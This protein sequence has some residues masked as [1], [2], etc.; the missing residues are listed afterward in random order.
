[1]K[2]YKVGFGFDVHSFTNKR[3][4]LVLGGL[5]IPFPLGLAA[6][7]DGDV[8]LHSIADAICGAAGLGDIGD[9]FP[10]SS[11]KSK[12]I[13]SRCIVDSIL[14][15]IKK[16]FEIVN[17]DITII[18]D[19][20]RLARYKKEMLKSLRSMLSLKDINVKIK[21]QEELGLFG[22]KNNICC[23]TLVLLKHG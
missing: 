6:V 19:K 18:A 21:S 13:N 16:K 5:K 22:D 1:M 11:R 15:K 2:D 4:N 17:M 23:M 8:V 3:K 10:P 12:G 14:N 9:Y 7:S 20:P